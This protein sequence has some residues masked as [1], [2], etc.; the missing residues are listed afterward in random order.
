MEIMLLKSIGKILFSKGTFIAL[1]I[2]GSSA[3][4]FFS[5][6]F[7]YD[8]GYDAANKHW[9][10]IESKRV[11]ELNEKILKLE[12]ESKQA[13]EDLRIEKET[14]ANKLNEI[15]ISTPKVQVL[16]VKTNTVLECGDVPAE[17]KM[18]STFSEAWNKLNEQAQ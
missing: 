9:Q 1:C 5:G 2:L 6:K 4:I 8:T 12:S 14:T 15:L 13:K 7:I 3:L 11:S 10:Q 17:V 18:D 16:D